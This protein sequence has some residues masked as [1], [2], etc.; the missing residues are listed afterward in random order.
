MAGIRQKEQTGVERSLVSH[1]VAHL[2]K[3]EEANFVET[4]GWFVAATNLLSV[5]A[6]QFQSLS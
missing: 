4:R 2:G 5:S 1:Q 6:S 3:K